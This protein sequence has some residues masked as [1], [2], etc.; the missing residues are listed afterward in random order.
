MATIYGECVCGGAHAPATISELA[1]DRCC[2]ALEGREPPE[3]DLELWLGAIGPFG[4]T[5]DAA[6]GDTAQGRRFTARFKTPL[7]PAIIEHFNA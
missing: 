6:Q 2:V 3:G 1:P 5:A 7:E 4:I